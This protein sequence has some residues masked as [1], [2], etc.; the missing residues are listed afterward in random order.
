MFLDNLLDYIKNIFSIDAGTVLGALFVALITFLFRDIL[1]PL[2]LRPFSWIREKF[3]CCYQCVRK[4]QDREKLKEILGELYDHIN[5]YDSLK[6]NMEDGFNIINDNLKIIKSTKDFLEKVE[7]EAK[8][9]I[10][11]KEKEL[12]V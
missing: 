8:E 3:K 7:K 4:D 10:S 6:K 1:K 11:K 5:E 12:F 2:L 9:A